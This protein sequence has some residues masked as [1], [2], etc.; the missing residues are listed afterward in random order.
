MPDVVHNAILDSEEGS[1]SSP[2][3]QIFKLAIG[4]KTG[5]V[6]TEDILEALTTILDY[7]LNTASFIVSSHKKE[8][9]LDTSALISFARQ[10]AALP[11][12]SKNL[13]DDM[14]LPMEP[15]ST[16]KELV[17]LREFGRF[18]IGICNPQ[19]YPKR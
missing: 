19:T 13:A 10:Q 3:Q 6:R 12:P 5:K 1:K 8:W 2:E 9:Q 14:W 7:R 16:N 15:T 4:D 18:F 11:R 17:R